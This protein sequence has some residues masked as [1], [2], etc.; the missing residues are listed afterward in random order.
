MSI[1]PHHDAGESDATSEK[2]AMALEHVGRKTRQSDVDAIVKDWL[3]RLS[4]D[5]QAVL[6][7]AVY[8]RIAAIKA[9]EA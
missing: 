7:Q 1:S 8:D 2:L 5:E 3:P 6:R 9:G 4:E